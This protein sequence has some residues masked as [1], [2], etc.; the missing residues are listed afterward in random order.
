[1]NSEYRDIVM[2]VLAL[3]FVALIFIGAVVLTLH[4]AGR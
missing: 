4:M 3:C 1:M 2:G